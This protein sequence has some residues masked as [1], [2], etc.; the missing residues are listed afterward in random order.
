[1][2]RFVIAD[3]SD[4]KSVLQELQAIVPVLPSVPIQPVIIAS[5]EEPGMFDHFRHYPGSCRSTAT[6]RQRNCSANSVIG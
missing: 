2:A 3:I 5:Q 6:R 4:A 1:M